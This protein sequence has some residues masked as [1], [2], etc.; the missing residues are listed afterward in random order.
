M[1]DRARISV[2]RGFTIAE[3]MAALALIGIT[4]CA[5]FQ[6][7][8]QSHELDRRALAASARAQAAERIMERTLALPFALISSGRGAID[9]REAGGRRGWTYEI[10]VRS[11]AG[12]K[13]V[14]VIVHGGG[15]ES[16][17]VTLTGPWRSIR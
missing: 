11:R 8:Y 13:E 6:I 15:R 1:S 14:E 4:L 5:S 7:L 12:P 17:L 3:S 10:E 16:R 2:P 9:P